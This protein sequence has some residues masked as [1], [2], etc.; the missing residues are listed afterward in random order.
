MDN[1]DLKPSD[2][3]LKNG[4]ILVLG[5][6]T[7]IKC[8]SITSFYTFFEMHTFFE[9]AIQNILQQKSFRGGL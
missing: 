3:R 9:K 6:M 8:L 1:V 4:K 7:V 2:L 5:C